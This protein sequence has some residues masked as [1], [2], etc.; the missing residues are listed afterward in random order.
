M[1]ASLLRKVGLRPDVDGPLPARVLRRPA[2]AHRHRARARRAARV[3]RLRRADQRARRL[4]P[5]ADRQPADGSAGRARRRVPLHLARPARRASH[6]PPRRRH[7][8]RASI[9]EQGTTEQLYAAPLHPYTR[10]LLGAVPT[11]DPEKK[12]LRIVAPGRR[13]LR[14]RSAAGCPFHP[15]CPRAIKG[16]CDK[17]MPQFAE[18]TP[19]TGH[20]V[21]CWNPHTDDDR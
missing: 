1:V 8:P 3:H 18:L 14:H 13:A 16:T 21:A 17:E 4:D 5:G 20:K 19:G 11:P 9:V 2:P 6:Q 10:A 7:V 12:R 15:R